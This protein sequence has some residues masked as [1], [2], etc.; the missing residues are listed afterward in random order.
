VNPRGPAV[1]EAFTAATNLVA[2]LED[3]RAFDGADSEKELARVKRLAAERPRI[4][5]WVD[6]HALRDA[7]E[8]PAVSPLVGE[9]EVVLVRVAHAQAPAPGMGPRRQPCEVD[10]LAA[11]AA[12]LRDEAMARTHAAPV[13]AAPV[14]L[15]PVAAPPV[16]A[17]PV[18]APPP[19]PPAK[20]PVAQLDGAVHFAVNSATL[21]MASRMRLD[22]VARS[23][24]S[25]GALRLTIEGYA[26]PRGGRAYNARLSRRR[27]QA[28]AKYLS[29]A[30]LD[31]TSATL[32][33]MGSATTA[34]NP[35]KQ[36][37]AMARRVNL[38][39]F[40]ADGREVEARRDATD[41]QVEAERAPRRAAPSP[42]ARKAPARAA[43]RPARGTP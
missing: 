19:A 28:V 2:L 11:R 18:V 4:D 7:K 43:K 25:Y 5:L 30:G 15:R 21:S 16:V 1:D 31:L 12:R 39:F 13:V 3:A 40:Q 33:A 35:T 8:W 10:L 24:A 41:L 20:A 27:A 17:L 36:E 14:V 37:L 42:R 26:D 6:A 9:M 23:L 22:S 32:R 29:D 34:K 38:R